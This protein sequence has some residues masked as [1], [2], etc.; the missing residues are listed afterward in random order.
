MDIRPLDANFAVAPQPRPDDLADL[1]AQGFRAVISNRPDGEEDGQPTAAIM[2]A[3]AE[4]AG[5]AFH[6][7]PTKPGEYSDA[8]IAAFRAVCRGTEGPVLAYCRTGMRATAFEAL[9]N[10]QGLPAAERLH[11]AQEAGYDLSALAPRL[12]D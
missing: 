11:R 10:P 6:H 12:G 2:R 4:A 8:G 5:L 1:A 3:A 7:L 9:A